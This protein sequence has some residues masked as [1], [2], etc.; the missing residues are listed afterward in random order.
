MANTYIALAIKFETLT[1]LKKKGAMYAP[2][3]LLTKACR[4]D[5]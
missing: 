3:F 1:T 2:F 5:V 4:L